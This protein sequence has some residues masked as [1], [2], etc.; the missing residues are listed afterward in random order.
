MEK[1]TNWYSIL[2]RIVLIVGMVSLLYVFL[3][4]LLFD[5]NS[6][7]WNFHLFYDNHETNFARLIVPVSQADW[8]FIR[9]LM[10]L[11]FGFCAIAGKHPEKLPFGF[12]YDYLV[13]FV[14]SLALIIPCGWACSY[15]IKSSV[16]P[17]GTA[18]DFL[19]QAE[20]LRVT[21]MLASGMF[22]GGGCRSLAQNTSK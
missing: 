10:M 14:L 8:F 20:W 6:L 9:P 4:S 3:A 16:P 12:K 13:W 5:Y 21:M 19:Y 22:L 18:V 2:R 15:G 7:S 17:H 11:C 1:Q